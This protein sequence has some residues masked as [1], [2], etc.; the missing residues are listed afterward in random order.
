MVTA[1]QWEGAIQNRVHTSASPTTDQVTPGNLG[2]F[3]FPQLK[4]GTLTVPTFQSY[5][6]QIQQY[7]MF[8]I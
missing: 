2:T 3:Q 7:N 6:N 4:M 1:I 5:E 8:G